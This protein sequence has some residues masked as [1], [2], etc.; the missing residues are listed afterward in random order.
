MRASSPE[1]RQ[2]QHK[3]DSYQSHVQA[4]D[5]WSYIHT[6]HMLK[7][8]GIRAHSV[9]NINY[10]FHSHRAQWPHSNGIL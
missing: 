4:K 6:L 7:Q 10:I 8:C 9:Q 2:S 5:L 3:T 1:T